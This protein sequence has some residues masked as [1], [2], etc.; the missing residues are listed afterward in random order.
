MVR[1]VEEKKNEDNGDKECDDF[2][3]CFDEKRY[4]NASRLHKMIAKNNKN[5]ICVKRPINHHENL[6]NYKNVKDEI[7]LY[8]M[9]SVYLSFIK[10]F[11]GVFAHDPFNK[12]KLSVGHRNDLY[13]FEHARDEITL[14]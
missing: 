10:T 5:E 3:A 13:D 14:I 6:Q 8:L 11:N 1:D 4:H 7:A 12:V 2:G 9:I